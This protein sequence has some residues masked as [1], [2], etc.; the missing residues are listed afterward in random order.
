MSK[1]IPKGT[2]RHGGFNNQ[3]PIVG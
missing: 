2:R 3:A 1:I